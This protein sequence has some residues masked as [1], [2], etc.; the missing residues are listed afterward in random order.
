MTHQIILALFALSL[1]LTACKPNTTHNTQIAQTVL[2]DTLEPNLK[3]VYTCGVIT[4]KGT[5]CKMHVKSLGAKCH[6]HNN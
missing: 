4:K 3:P 5:P 1:L 6:F 2:K